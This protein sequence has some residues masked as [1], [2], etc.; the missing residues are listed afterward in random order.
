MAKVL[1]LQQPPA[2][3]ER[4]AVRLTKRVVES[5]SPD[6]RRD[7]Q[8]RDSEIKGFGVRVKPSGVRTYF[9]QYRDDGGRT[10]RLALGRHGVLTTEAAR[11]QAIQRLADVARGLNPSAD[12]RAART[13][14]KRTQ[15]VRQL[16]ERF[17]GEH[18]DAKRKPRT[19]ESYRSLLNTHALPALGHLMVDAVTRDDVES[20]HLRMMRMPPTANRVLAVLS[21]MFNLAEAWRLRPLQSN[22]CYR[23]ER[24]VERAR[25]R[26]Y[27]DD[28]L[29]SIGRALAEAERTQTGNPGAIIA[30]RLLALTGCRASEILGLCWA[31]VDLEAGVLRLPG[32]KA[33]ARAVPLGTGTG[34]LSSLPAPP[35]AIATVLR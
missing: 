26:F 35:G 27:S 31:H 30:I 17:M 13:R 33:G 5:I 25:D 16:V 4:S 19:A 12:R 28:E 1:R 20:L 2:A 14:A 22:P 7:V 24:Y 8:R 18:V 21:K 29:R 32:A 3:R 10:R 34:R 15:T 6:P 23:L 9:L 11:K